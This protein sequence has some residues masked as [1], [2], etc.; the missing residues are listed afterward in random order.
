MGGIFGLSHGSAFSSERKQSSHKLCQLGTP[1]GINFSGTV[2]SCAGVLHLGQAT[3]GTGT[4]I[5]IL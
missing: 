1:S 5:L 4:F 2:F 3:S